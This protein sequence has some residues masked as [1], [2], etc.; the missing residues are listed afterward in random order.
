MQ[1]VGSLYTWFNQQSENPI[2]I[3]LDRVLI[4]DVWL[5]EFPSTFCSTQS[6]SSSD[7]CPLIVD[8][9]LASSTKHRF[10]FKNYWT[11]VDKYWDLLLNA[12]SIP[13][14]GNP[15]SS[16]CKTL[17]Q[18]KRDIKCESWAHSSLVKAHLD[19]LHSKQKECLA[20]I[21]QCPTDC[22]LNSTLKGINSKIQNFTKLFTSWTIQ[23]AKVKWLKQGEEDLKFLYSRIKSRQC[24]GKAVVNMFSTFPNTDRSEVINAII[25][26][27]Q[28]LYNPAPPPLFDV[29]LFPIGSVFP[30]S[31][32]NIITNPI[33]DDE[34]KKA[35]F[36]GSSS[37]SPGP[38]GFNFHFYKTA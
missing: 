14:Y 4:N 38:D 8:S 5:N 24:S 20:Q 36:L 17:K 19:N 12:I 28:S 3:K 1:S 21:Q 13:I 27:F 7:H 32:C 11:D 9:G 16:L 34:I 2:H 37:S 25:H 30:A 18:L 22:M 15:L 29:H 26:H 10:L 31:F 6:P 23:R 33:L 35:V